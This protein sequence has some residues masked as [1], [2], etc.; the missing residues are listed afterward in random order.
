M[1]TG[2]ASVDLMDHLVD[3]E[4]S[5]VLTA[6]GMAWLQTFLDEF[7]FVCLG[8]A[9]K[10]VRATPCPNDR[11]VVSPLNRCSLLGQMRGTFDIIANVVWCFKF[12]RPC[13]PADH[14]VLLK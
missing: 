7:V 4:L 1:T 14:Y 6:R 9:D 3:L 8:R 13:N 10:V 12:G 5:R 2:Q 11:L